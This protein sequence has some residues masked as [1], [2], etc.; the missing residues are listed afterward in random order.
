MEKFEMK[1]IN[2][3]FVAGFLVLIAII[4]LIN[5]CRKSNIENTF[6]EDLNKS[7]ELQNINDP[8]YVNST[9]L[10]KLAQKHNI[11]ISEKFQATKTQKD[12]LELR[13]YVLQQIK[14]QETK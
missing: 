13:D 14:L 4:V 3:H 12:M 2:Y 5:S 10:I 7:I 11:D 6:E 8:N 9:E 1:K